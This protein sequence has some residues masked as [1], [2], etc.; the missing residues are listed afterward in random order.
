MAIQTEK[1]GL[2]SWLIAIG[3]FIAGLISI[4]LINRF[5]YSGKGSDFNYILCIIIIGGYKMWMASVGTAAVK[6]FFQNIFKGIFKTLFGF[7]FSG[8]IDKE[9]RIM[10]FAE[11]VRRGKK[12]FLWAGLIPV[13]FEG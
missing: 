1:A 12:K 11:I 9:K 5:L 6:C 3:V 2:Q 13:P 7:L 4:A 10:K 8:K